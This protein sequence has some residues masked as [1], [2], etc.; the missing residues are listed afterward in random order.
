MKIYFWLLI[1]ILSIVLV[2]KSFFICEEKGNQC[3]LFQLTKV[4][5]SNQLI[6]EGADDYEYF[7]FMYLT[8]NNIAQFKH[9]FSDTNILRYPGG[10][11]YEYGYDGAFAVL[12][13]AILYFVTNN[14][15]TSYNITVILIL[16]LNV[17]LSFYFFRKIGYLKNRDDKNLD[18]KSFIAALVF[19]YSALVAARLN[20]HLNLAFVGGFPVFLY[21][22]ISIWQKYINTIKT[23]PYD[24]FLLVAGMLLIL[25]GTLQ[26]LILASLLLV[27]LLIYVVVSERKVTEKT[28]LVSFFKDNFSLILVSFVSF[29]LVFT[30]FYWGYVYALL[31]NSLIRPE[32]ANKLFPPSVLDFF[33]PNQYLGSWWNLLNS[34]T[35][36]IEKVISVG[37]VETAIAFVLLTSLVIKRKLGILSLFIG[38]IVLYVISSYGLI[39]MPFFP[40]GGR[41][42]ILISLFISYLIVASS[43][44]FNKKSILWIILIAI[45]VERFF[46]GIYVTKPIP[47]YMREIVGNLPGDAVLNIPSSKYNQSRDVYPYLYEKNILD[48]YIHYTADNV[49]GNRNFINNIFEKFQC[50]AER[51][52]K[53]DNKFT[54]KMKETLISEMKKNNVEVVVLHKGAGFMNYN[55]VGCKNVVDWWNYLNPP[56]VV[57]GDK[58]LGASELLFEIK[59]GEN[60]SSDQSIRFSNYGKFYLNG[61]FV[62]PNTSEI[63]LEAKDGLRVIDNWE[64]INDGKKVSYVP[65]LE[66]ETALGD[67][68]SFHLTNKTSETTYIKVYYAFS[69]YVQKSVNSDN[70]FKKVFEDESFI[71]YEL[72]N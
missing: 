59:P 35:I 31:N 10:F 49:R 58:N 18:L 45:I 39:R 11:D 36:S 46:F 66:L 9:P 29:L 1:I 20:S 55:Y 41:L 54:E 52:I 13:G 50:N 56:E 28:R 2:S 7:G 3:N 61:I 70:P 14:L 22:L 5:F 37:L 65:P 63:S 43:Q 19:G 25:F 40:E 30:F 62:S 23:K 47:Q 71:V 33:V 27:G 16:F 57:I 69:P 6:G 24:W 4:N 64:M 51:S 48:G 60:S 38:L 32:S 17:I 42:V 67:Q 15:V 72:V 12:V 34:S 26:Y 21:A 44:I 8:K 53:N 68:L